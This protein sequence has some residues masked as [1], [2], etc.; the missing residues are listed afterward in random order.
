M[1]LENTFGTLKLGVPFDPLF[2]LI[3]SVFPTIFSAK[4][5]RNA[6]LI[7]TLEKTVFSKIRK[8]VNFPIYAQLLI[9]Q[10]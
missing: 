8:I 7:D 5:A 4:R 1:T 6:K 10:K 9:V 2:L 3:L